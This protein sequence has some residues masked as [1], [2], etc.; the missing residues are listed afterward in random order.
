MS[1]LPIGFSRD[2]VVGTKEAASLLNYSIPHFRR[3]YRAGKV[4]TPIRLSDRK[5]G[6]RVGVL[7]DCIRAADSK[8]AA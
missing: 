1:E 8:E 3:L 6:W 7:L 4:P 2:Q 5:L